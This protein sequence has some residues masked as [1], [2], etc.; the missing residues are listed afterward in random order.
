MK[1]LIWAVYRL[2]SERVEELTFETRKRAVQ[3]LLQLNSIV[4][5]IPH[6]RPV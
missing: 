6:F 5:V 2:I 1:L 4:G 3:G